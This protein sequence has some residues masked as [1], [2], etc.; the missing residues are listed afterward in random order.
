MIWKIGRKDLLLNLMMFRFLVG[1]IVTVALTAVLMPVLLSDYERQW[2][3]YHDSVAAD[4]A[5]LM[6]SKVYD[7]VMSNHRVYRPPAVLS[8][9][10]RGIESQ[11]SS[12]A[13]IDR[14]SIPE[15]GGGAVAANPCL[16]I[17]QSLDLSL[18]Y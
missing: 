9:F 14:Y 6:A 11:V 12:S 2:K 15:L 10:S 1:T 13:S 7:H 4:E 18:L 8:V 17:L 16:A 3:E 5:E